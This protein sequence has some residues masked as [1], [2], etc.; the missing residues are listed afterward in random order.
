MEKQLLHLISIKSLLPVP[1]FLKQFCPFPYTFHCLFILFYL[2]LFYFYSFIYFI[3]DCFGSQL[4]QVGS[5]LGPT[6]FSLVVVCRR[7][8]SSLQPS[9]SLLALWHVGSQFLDQRSI[10]TRLLN[11][12]V[13]FSPLDHQGSHYLSSSVSASSC[14]RDFGCSHLV[15][16]GFLS[17]FYG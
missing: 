1:T 3:F 4:W 17:K 14:R 10:E 15:N 13:A 5:S 7:G 12:K 2:F 9:G 11:S 6:S 8:L 16:S